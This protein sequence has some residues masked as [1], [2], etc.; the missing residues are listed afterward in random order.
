M[1]N[2]VELFRRDMHMT[3]EQLALKANV[4]R[5]TIINIENGNYSDLKASTM[6]GIARALGRSIDDCFYMPET[7]ST[8]NG[9]EE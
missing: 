7:S 5:L 3:Q 6:S 1:K 8:L 9:K 4:S 2:N